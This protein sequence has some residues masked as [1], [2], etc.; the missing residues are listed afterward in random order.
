M[1][2][3]LFSPHLG[4]AAFGMYE[5]FGTKPE[6]IFSK[7]ETFSEESSLQLRWPDV[8]WELEGTSRYRWL[9]DNFEKPANIDVVVSGT[10]FDEHEKSWGRLSQQLQ[11]LRPKAIVMEVSTKYFS[12][13]QIEE[14]PELRTELYALAHKHGY[15]Y[16]II[17]T[18]P[19]LHGHPDRYERCFVILWRSK[20]TPMV[21]EHLEQDDPAYTIEEFLE[22]Y[23]VDVPEHI[24]SKTFSDLLFNPYFQFAL[25]KWGQARWHSTGTGLSLQDR[26]IELGIL[27]EFYTWLKEQSPRFNHEREGIRRVI[28]RNGVFDTSPKFLSALVKGVRPTEL[29]RVVHPNF[30]SP[31]FLT[32]PETFAIAGYHEQQWA[33]I[34][35]AMSHVP[36][37]TSIATKPDIAPWR[38]WRDIGIYVRSVVEG[39]GMASR[40]DVYFWDAERGVR[41]KRRKPRKDSVAKDY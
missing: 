31:R 8:Q 23:P 14:A 39:R 17:N 4:K 20:M 2:W 29:T 3:L 36:L 5:A 9:V 18:K 25:K 1:R 33:Y 34:L 11:F 13:Y 6:I 16:S 26:F 38:V 41:V 15:S 37:A 30:V 32:W 28:E 21:T 12:S 22:R 7:L 24:V 40:E 19:W 27:G 10:M 35:A